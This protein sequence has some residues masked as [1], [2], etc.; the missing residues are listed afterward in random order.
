MPVNDLPPGK[1]TGL[2]IGA[3]WPGSA[4][5]DILTSRADARQEIASAMECYADLLREIHDG[6]L[7]PQDGATADDARN[8]FRRGELNARGIA[9]RNETKS[10]SYEAANQYTAH[11]RSELFDLAIRGNDAIDE[12]NKSKISTP[13][14]VAA[15]V[16]IVTECRGCASTMAARTVGEIYYEIQ[17]VLDTQGMGVSARVFAAESGLTLPEWTPAD[18]EKLRNEITGQLHSFPGSAETP[19]ANPLVVDQGRTGTAAVSSSGITAERSIPHVGSPSVR[20]GSLDAATGGPMPVASSG[21]TSSSV[22]SISSTGI[23]G[24]PRPDS[25]IS[26]L[27]APPV[28]I[29]SSSGIT[30]MPVPSDAPPHARVASAM[31]ITP[32]VTTPV[33]PVH[34]GGIPHIEA[35]APT[36]LPTHVNAVGGLQSGAIFSPEHLAETFNAGQQIGSPVSAAAEAISNAAASP[37][38]TPHTASI[39]PLEAPTPATPL[40]E[41][42]HAAAPAPSVIQMPSSPTEVAHP[43]LT[44]AP[45][46]APTI[47]A[48]PISPAVQAAPPSSLLA[49]GADVRPSAVTAPA[50]PALPPPA[51]PGSAPVN[52]ASAGQPALVRQQPTVS[53]PHAP[54]AGLTERAVAATAT[55]AAAG[56]AAENAAAQ[57]RLQRL[58]DAVARQRPRLRWA[59]GDLEDGSTV[60]V[61]DLADG[62]IPPGVAIPTGVRLLNP[63]VRRG[64]LTALLGPAVHIAAYQPGQHL[65]PADAAPP[66]AMSVR[67]RDTTAV[68]DLGWELSQATKWRD[69]LPR[70]AHTLAKA[71]SSGT[72]VLESEAELLR[73]HMTVVARAVIAGYPAAVDRAQV[74]NWQLLATIDALISNEK[75]LANY[76]FAWFQA[77][78]LTREGRR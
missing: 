68:D 33:A 55:G 69:G 76:H 28:A 24:S 35:A 64:D 4:A 8:T 21:L 14:K 62:W 1:W 17:T 61:T 52:S 5:L 20:A 51:L 67:A 6:N 13:E 29:E 71:V 39:A 30:G 48:P 77:H 12:V 32:P 57:S 43:V 75:R 73:D 47:Q 34:S 46:I 56:I 27:P 25:R 7:I 31:A 60:L 9:H 18:V 45:A 15:I 72:G 58:L 66:P 49:Y 54:A 63:A 78:A 26:G 70:L 23:T 41:T 11:L 10:R 36:A 53:T 42:A 74:G 59:I 50:A 40:V 3:Q 44:P 22:A 38:H 19:D 2:L 65:P 16:G 37:V